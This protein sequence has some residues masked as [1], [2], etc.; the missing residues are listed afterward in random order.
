M[1]HLTATR[2]IGLDARQAGPRWEWLPAAARVPGPGTCKTLIC[3]FFSHHTGAMVLVY[4]LSG[5][6]VWTDILESTPWRPL[7]QTG[8]WPHA[9]ID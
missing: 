6:D 2:D 5:A 1:T 8:A 9:E 4:E 7:Q 3:D